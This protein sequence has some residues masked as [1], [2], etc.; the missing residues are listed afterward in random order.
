MRKNC[1]KCERA[2]AIWH[3][4]LLLMRAKA[5]RLRRNIILA[6]ILATQWQRKVLEVR[7][8]LLQLL[9]KAFAGLVAI[10]IH[11]EG[12]GKL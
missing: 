10:G 5:S 6:E 8:K 7:Q 1:K 12:G 11:V 2:R 9:E 4:P 3:E